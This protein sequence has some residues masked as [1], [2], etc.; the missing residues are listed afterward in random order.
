MLGE[1]KLVDTWFIVPT[2][3]MG[4]GGQLHQVL[5]ATVIFRQKQEMVVVITCATV[6]NILSEVCLDADDRVDSGCFACLVKFDHAIH[7]SMIGNSEMLH[8]VFFRLLHQFLRAAEAV[9]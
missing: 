5:V 7:C 3:C 2:L 8:T 4:D 1:N 6:I 9:Q